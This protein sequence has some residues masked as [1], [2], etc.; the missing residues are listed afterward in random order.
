MDTRNNSKE[1]IES[2]LL[3]I[4]SA[5]PILSIPASLYRDWQNNIELKSIQETLRLH[6]SELLRHEDKIDEKYLK[7]DEYLFIL[8]KTINKAKNEFRE[9]KKQIFSDFLTKSCFRR[10]IDNTDKLIFLEMLDKLELEH[11]SFITY[12]NSLDVTS[13]VGWDIDSKMYKETGKDE[14]RLN[15]L[16]SYFISLGLVSPKIEFK[17][18]EDMHMIQESGYVISELC[19]DLINFLKE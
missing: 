6:A 4:A 8:H 2:G 15:L 16:V 12:L 19:V 10:N 17:I 11:L 13:R 5:F 14:R 9:E 7:S 18:N 1:M 3:A